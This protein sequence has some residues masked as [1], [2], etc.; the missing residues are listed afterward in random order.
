MKTSTDRKFATHRVAA[1]L[2]LA[3]LAMAPGFATAQD[4]EPETASMH[5]QLSDLDLASREGYAQA[6]ERLTRAASRLCQQV[7]KARYLEAQQAKS[8]CINEALAQVMPQVERAAVA[9][10]LAAS[11]APVAVASTR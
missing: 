11:N 1:L 9:R 3:L 10:R 5:V 6:R 8:D 4:A 2:P 7:V